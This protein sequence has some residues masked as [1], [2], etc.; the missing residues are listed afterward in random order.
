[1]DTWPFAS[2]CSVALCSRYAT[3]APPGLSLRITAM[4]DGVVENV[5]ETTLPAASRTAGVTG[6]QFFVSST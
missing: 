3:T 1:M 2:S 6:S 4:T 5:P